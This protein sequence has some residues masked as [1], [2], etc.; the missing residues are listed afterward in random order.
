VGGF[1]ELDGNG[2]AQLYD[3]AGLHCTAILKEQELPKGVASGQ[4]KTGVNLKL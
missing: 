2:A 3:M 1:G 4:E